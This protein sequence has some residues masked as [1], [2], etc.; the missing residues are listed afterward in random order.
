[1]KLDILIAAAALLF[2]CNSP[3]PPCAGIERAEAAVDSAIV[4][5]DRA[6]ANL[7][8]AYSDGV[9]E[10]ATVM[11]DILLKHMVGVPKSAINEMKAE[12]KAEVKRKAETKK[13]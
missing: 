6:E 11:S 3:Q 7:Q 5:V 4:A 10:G 8:A 13:Y 2:S 1:M 12:M 9:Y